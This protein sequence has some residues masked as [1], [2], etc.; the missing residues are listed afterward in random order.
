MPSAVLGAGW[1]GRSAVYCLRPEGADQVVPVLWG[2]REPPLLPGNHIQCSGKIL[3]SELLLYVAAAAGF[4]RPFADPCALSTR[5]ECAP[6]PGHLHLH[7]G[8]VP[9]SPGSPGNVGQ[10]GR[11]DWGRF[12]QPESVAYLHS[13]GLLPQ[14][15]GTVLSVKYSKC[16]PLFLLRIFIHSPLP[17][18][19]SAK[20]AVDLDKWVC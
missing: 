20:Q 4:V 13:S 15:C 3:A 16:L 11:N 7:P 8:A 2:L 10:H 1:P 17:F 12:R 9:L 19:L 18:L 6:R 14:V 5:A